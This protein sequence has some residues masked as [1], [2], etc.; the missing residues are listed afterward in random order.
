MFNENF[1]FDSPRSP[2][3]DSNTTTTTQQSSRSVSPCSAAGPFPSPRFSVTDLATQFAGQR[4]RKESTICYDSCE[5]YANNDDDAGWSIP[6]IDD[7][8]CYST[9]SRSRT[10]PQRP[11]SPSRRVQRQLHTRLLCTPSHHRDISALVSR[12]VDAKEQCSITPPGSTTPVDDH[13]DEGYS[14]SD[15]PGLSSASRRSSVATVKS[16]QSYRRSSDMKS[17]GACVSKNVRFRRDRDPKR[18]QRA[19]T[20]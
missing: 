18:V 14:S 12:M 10:F 20:S 6:P 8:N 5:S 17:T 1:S 13:E 16:R 4:L 2:S 19:E 15:E 9:L 7:D 3:L 11:H